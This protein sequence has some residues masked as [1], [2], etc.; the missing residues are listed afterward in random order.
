MEPASSDPLDLFAVMMPVFTHDRCANCHGGVDPHDESS[1][2]H[3]GGFRP[4]D[5]TCADSGCHTQTDDS[6]PETK[7]KTAS[8]IHSFGGRTANELCKMQSDV[9]DD[10]NSRRPDGYFHHLDTDF[11]IDLAF[12]GLSGGASDTAASPPMGKDAFLRAARAWLY[13]GAKCKPWT[14]SITQ[15][16]TFASSYSF[17]LGGEGSA[18]RVTVNEPAQR[19]LTVDRVEGVSTYR[20][21]QG[22][23]QHMLTVMQMEGCEL[24][25]TSNSRWNGQNQ[26]PERGHGNIRIRPDGSYTIRLVGPMEKTVTLDSGHASTNCPMT[27]PGSTADT[28]VLDWPQWKTTIHCPANFQQDPAGGNTIDCDLYDPRTNPRLKGTMTRT[29]RSHEDAPDPASWLEVSPVGISRADTGAQMPVTVVT[30]WD[31]KLPP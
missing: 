1:N 16:E 13:L 29:L 25:I 20:I 22:G 9:A 11:L 30:T 6:N 17:P 10:L 8:P 14:G 5:A 21:N 12:V 4:V 24:T 28:T 26:A 3:A 15:H 31:L 7:W 23:H 2:S 27:P 18:T 19:I